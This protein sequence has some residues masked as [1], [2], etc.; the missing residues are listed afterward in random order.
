MRVSD[1][2]TR[3]RQFKFQIHQCCGDDRLNMD[4]S[5]SVQ[6]IRPIKVES[7]C[8]LNDAGDADAGQ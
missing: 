1:D 6:I 4:E 2:A 3:T 8:G 5:R 7:G